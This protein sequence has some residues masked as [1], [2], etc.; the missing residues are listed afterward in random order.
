MKKQVLSFG[1]HPD[2]IEIG[3]AGTEYQLIQ[4]GYEVNHVYITSGEA[5]SQTIP[6]TQLAQLRENEARQSA[7]VLGVKSVEFLRCADGLTH[8]TEADRVQVINLIRRIQPE[9]IFVHGKCDKFPDHAIV[10]QLVMSAITAAAGPWFQDSEGAPWSVK[11]VFGFEVWH[12]MPSFQYASDITQALDKKLE[13]LQC[14]A[15][16]V[17]PTRYDEAF[18]GLARYRGVMSWAGEYAEV[19]EVLKTDLNIGQA[20]N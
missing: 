16:Q 18:K 11:Q 8:F 2:D 19:F 6:K 20:N 14:F 15:S 12:P 1:A 13:A 7:S 4:A 10:H 3:C 17:G 9:I 5:G